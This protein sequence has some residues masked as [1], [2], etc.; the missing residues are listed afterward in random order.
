MYWLRTTSHEGEC[1]TSLG[2]HINNDYMSTLWK[3]MN[4]IFTFPWSEKIIKLGNISYR[5][6]KC[7]P[8][9]GKLDVIMCFILQGNFCF[10]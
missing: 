2:V 1:V 10:R 9:L 5:C 6:E 3:S 8:L 4:E 7:F